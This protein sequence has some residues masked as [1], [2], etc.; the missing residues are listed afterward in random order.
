MALGALGSVEDPSR[1]LISGAPVF[2]AAVWAP[3]GPPCSRGDSHMSP[4]G[5]CGSRQ[6]FCKGAAEAGG[7][8]SSKGTRALWGNRDGFRAGCQSIPRDWQNRDKPPVPLDPQGARQGPAE[9]SRA[10]FKAPIRALRVSK[11]RSM[12]LPR[13]SRRIPLGM[14]FQGLCCSSVGIF[15]AAW[16]G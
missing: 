5:C 15:G 6:D 9:G 10:L 14:W 12:P 2:G 7:S 1:V 3:Q 13:T 11:V 16:L 8:E 4:S